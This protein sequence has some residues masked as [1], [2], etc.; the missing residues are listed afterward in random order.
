MSLKHFSDYFCIYIQIQSFMLV[1]MFL[2]E[3]VTLVMPNCQSCLLGVNSGLVPSFGSGSI[4]F[5]FLKR[6]Y[7]CI[8]GQTFT[9]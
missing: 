6:D 9:L 4:F 1:K 7:V 2:I 8:V 3:R 5:L